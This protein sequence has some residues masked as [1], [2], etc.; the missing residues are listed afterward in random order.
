MI[1]ECPVTVA[2]FPPIADPA[3]YYS[4]G[5]KSA[6]SG[7]NNVVDLDIRAELNI[8]EKIMEGIAMSLFRK[9]RIPCPW[10]DLLLPALLS[11][12]SQRKMFSKLAQHLPRAR[13]KKAAFVNTF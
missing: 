3:L 12:Q 5:H 13:P 7:L 8:G 11:S 9:Y 6:S 1:E 4:V 2:F 10:C